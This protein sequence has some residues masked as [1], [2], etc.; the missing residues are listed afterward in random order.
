MACTYNRR[1]LD[2]TDPREIPFDKEILVYNQETFNTFLKEAFPSFFDGFFNGR[3]VLIDSGFK[4]FQVSNGVIQL[5]SAP[6]DYLSS[7]PLKPQGIGTLKETGILT[8]L[9][10]PPGIPQ[11]PD[12]RINLGFVGGNQCESGFYGYVGEKWELQIPVIKFC[13]FNV[14]IRNTGVAPNGITAFDPVFLVEPVT[15]AYEYIEQIKNEY[16]PIII[17]DDVSIKAGKGVSIVPDYTA[18]PPDTFNATDYDFGEVSFDG[19]EYTGTISV[20]NNGKITLKV[21]EITPQKNANFS[22][23]NFIP[24]DPIN[25][26]PLSGFELKQGETKQFEVKYYPMG[27]FGVTHEVTFEYKVITEAGID[28]N[29]EKITSTLRARPYKLSI[30]CPDLD[31]GIVDVKNTTQ[32]NEIDL[33]IQ[34]NGSKDVY[35]TGYSI[36]GID[37]QNFLNVTI[38]DVSSNSP[39]LFEAGKSKSFKISYNPQNLYNVIHTGLID[40]KFYR[41]NPIT[42]FFDEPVIREKLI[43]KLRAKAFKQNIDILLEE[44]LL[45]VLFTDDNG[46]Y[47]FKTI[48]RIIEKSAPIRKWKTKG[49]WQ[50][51]GEHLY[52]FFTGSTSKVNNQY[53]LSVFNDEFGTPESYHQFDIAFGHKA[54]SGS[55]YTLNSSNLKPSQT[56][57]RKYLVECYPPTS[58]SSDR[59]P[60]KFKF[61]NN[62]N[63]D[64]VYFIQMDR[65]HFRE[66][67]DP[68]N[69][70]IALCPLTS[71]ANQLFNTGSNVRVDQTSGTIYTLIDESFDTNQS[72]TDKG[73]LDDWYY[74]TSGSLQDGI[75]GEESDNAWG[76][77]F[78][79][80]GLIILDG[81]VLDQSCSF[82]TVT[83][84]IDG[85][86]AHK[87][88]LS[89]SGSSSSTSVRNYS[90]SFYARSSE[91]VVK[92]TYFCHV[93]LDEF[94]YSNS[95]TYFSG[96]S[97]HLKYDGF[98]VEPN[99]YIT[100]IGLYNSYGDMLAIG[101][102]KTPILKNRHKTYVF[103]VGVIIK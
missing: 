59:L 14:A 21:L 73:L 80:K 35:L 95:P 77:V 20:T 49:L 72:E 33:T 34:N 83:A 18:C 9:E 85:Q 76:I 88:F 48:S 3:G 23:G 47:S 52:S 60:E 4:F 87:L 7:I 39:L 54:G 11:T 103:Q 57:Y 32:K 93:G 37:S 100:S 86:N 92:E 28:V 82:N 31:W 91:E 74:I 68:G 101:K 29:G 61:K 25:L 89:I 42:G 19:S 63:G 30:V 45:D 56:M 50:C 65:E 97:N 8:K 96:S 58:K 24:L 6:Y 64:Y 1:F 81:V 26:S 10:I 38:P 90:S 27:E 22:I 46:V 99:T 12:G 15:G 55:K 2:P 41:Q 16:G 66:M 102:L 70:Q 43:S 51:S 36:G 67:L 44:D 79:K 69:F 62:V 53:Y 17:P 13:Y 98:K 78:P 94:N 75:Y 5:S 71:S 40:F 84:S